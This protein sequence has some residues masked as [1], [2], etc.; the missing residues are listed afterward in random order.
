MNFELT[1]EQKMIQDMTRDFAQNE[2]LPLAAELDETG[3]FPE[4]LVKKMAELGLMGM[5]VPEE[6]GGPGLDYISYAIAMEEISR[7]CAGTAVIMSVNN[8]LVCEPLL[9]FGNEEQ[10]KKYLTPLAQGEKLGCFGLTEPGAGSDAASQKTTAVRDGDY[11][12]VNGTK[13]FITNAPEADYCILFTMTDKEKR[14]KGI[15]AFILDMKSEGV[16]VGKPEKKLGIKASHSASII[17]EDVKIP[18]ENRLGEE[19]MGFKVAMATLDAGRIGIAAQAVGIAR[20][21]LEDALAYAKERQQF[22]QPIANFQAIQWMLADM[23]TEI[24]A[25]RLLTW[26]AAYLKDKGIRHSKES[27]MA[28]LFAA[29]VAMRSAV[30]C[31]QIHGGYGYIKEYPAERHFRDAKITE[32]YEG[33]SEIQRLV[34]ANALLR[35]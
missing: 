3:R 11:Y 21:C 24:D 33:T 2:V 7:A 16:T 35:D 18:V 32:I 26:R 17:L 27:S 5:A 34:I 13:N 20:A 29:E 30:K 31:I 22:G 4:E 25:A 12:I 15:T 28:K 19:G 10:K 1:D 9:K 23:A 8:S 6:Y 14:H